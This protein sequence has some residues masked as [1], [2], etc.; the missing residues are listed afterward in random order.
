MPLQL[1]RDGVGGVGRKLDAA[2]GVEAVDRLE[3][4]HRADLDEVVDRLSPVAEAPG[5]VLGQPE[6]RL[7]QLPPDGRVASLGQGDELLPHFVSLRV[8]HPDQPASWSR[9]FRI[10]KVS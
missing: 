5:E 10:Q 8:L 7:H 9:R 3:Q 1:A 4:R 2:P 6:V